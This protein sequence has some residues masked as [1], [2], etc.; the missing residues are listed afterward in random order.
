[1]RDFED[2]L[3]NELHEVNN[4]KIFTASSSSSK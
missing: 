1:M 3:E 4:N 2:K